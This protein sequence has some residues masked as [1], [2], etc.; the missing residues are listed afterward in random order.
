[1][2]EF[3]LDAVAFQ[4]VEEH[5]FRWDFPRVELVDAKTLSCR[6]AGHEPTILHA[7][8][9]P[10]SWESAGVRR[11]IYLH[12]L[13]RLL[14]APDVELRVPAELLEILATAWSVGR[15]G[16]LWAFAKK[17]VPSEKGGLLS[18]ASAE[19]IFLSIVG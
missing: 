1:M 12:L 2:S 4:P 7:C 10:K 14:T 16:V 6:H 8:A 3:P 17:Y 11:N 19:K 18:T 15:V 9:V 5:V 13:R